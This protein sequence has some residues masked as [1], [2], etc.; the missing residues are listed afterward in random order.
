MGLSLFSADSG[1]KNV[2]LDRRVTVKIHL[3]LIKHKFKA[4]WPFFVQM[5]TDETFATGRALA[6]QPYRE[7]AADVPKEIVQKLIDLKAPLGS[8]TLAVPLRMAP[9]LAAFAWEGMLTLALPSSGKE[10][11]DGT[12]Q[13]WRSGVHAKRFD[14]Q[15]AWESCTVGGVCAPGWSLLV[16]NGWRPGNQVMVDRDVSRFGGQTN[17]K[18][19]HLIGSSIMTSAG[20]QFQIQRSDYGRKAEELMRTQAIRGEILIRPDSL[21][22][23]GVAV[24]VVQA[25]PVETLVRFDTDREQAAYLRAF[26]NEVFAAGAQTVIVLPA[27]SSELAQEVL[28]VLRDALSG[29]SV[30]E[31]KQILDALSRVR[32]AI[33]QWRLPAL[34]IPDSL[35]TNEG[36]FDASEGTAEW[37]LE[38]ALDVCLFSASG[39]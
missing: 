13:F 12:F 8:R 30:P 19:L 33:V 11:L 28:R 15:L 35:K 29:R 31:L 16:E 7:A 26:A 25:E 18:I 3:W 10:R 23:A 32:Q 14:P 17:L 39:H 36:A 6:L 1:S 2:V 38:L 27:L 21:P 5:P 34:E 37:L 9:E 4:W 20:V 24:V 22:L